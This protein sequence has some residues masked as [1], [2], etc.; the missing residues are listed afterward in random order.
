[1]GIALQAELARAF[2]VAREALRNAAEA[3]RA[4]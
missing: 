2:D 1:M 4:A 3:M